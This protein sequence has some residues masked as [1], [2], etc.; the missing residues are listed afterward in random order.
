MG[1]GTP[2]GTTL[3][4]SAYT[5]LDPNS[6]RLVG[7]VSGVTPPDGPGAVILSGF[8]NDPVTGARFEHGQLTLRMEPEL[9]LE[10]AKRLL[11]AIAQNEALRALPRP[12]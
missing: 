1:T 5:V 11:H 7:T 8:V 9:A 2:G 3:H 12:T 4:G 10:V 6:S